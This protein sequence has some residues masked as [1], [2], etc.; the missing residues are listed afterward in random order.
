MQSS[1]LRLILA[2]SAVGFLSQTVA[3][4]SLSLVYQFSEVGSWVENIAVRPN[5]RL[6]VTRADVPQLWEV[7]PGTKT[8]SLVHTFPN[9]SSLTGISEISHDSYAVAG[10]V[11]DLQT[12]AA[13][14]GTCAVFKVTYCKASSSTKPTVSL[15]NEIQEANFLNGLTTLDP[16]HVLIADSGRGVVWHLDVFTGT[17]FVAVDDP[18]FKIDATTNIPLGVNGIKIWHEYLY[19]TS[20]SQQLFGRIALDGQG[21]PTTP[22]HIIARGFIPDDFSLAEDST[23]YIQTDPLNTVLRVN[24]DGKVSTVAGALTSLE[25][26]GATSSAWHRGLVGK[27]LYITATGGIAA[28]VNGTAVEPGKIVKMVL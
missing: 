21:Q 11:V 17:Y 22:A 7:D 13:T 10:L 6:L 1:L 24:R 20:T 18:A 25:L 5:G 9:V 2:A 4:A 12:F 27:V 16:R 3:A 26:A 28:P 19:F 15:I 14:P 23:A 8:A